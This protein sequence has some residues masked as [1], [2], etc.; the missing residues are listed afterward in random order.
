MTGL[1]VSFRW[2][3]SELHVA[4]WSAFGTRLPRCNNRSKPLHLDAVMGKA[5]LLNGI[6]GKLLREVAKLTERAVR[7]R[8]IPCSTSDER[9]KNTTTWHSCSELPPSLWAAKTSAPTLVRH[10]RHG[11]VPFCALSGALGQRPG[12]LDKL[13]NIPGVVFRRIPIPLLE[14]SPDTLKQTSGTRLST[15]VD[16]HGG[17][18]RSPAE[19]QQRGWPPPEGSDWTP[20][21]GLTSPSRRMFFAAPAGLPQVPTRDTRSPLQFTACRPRDLLRALGGCYPVPREKN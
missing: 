9:S 7:Q 8:A 6:A 17:S 5:A 12:R 19:G 10:W 15:C 14:G 2:A 20:S 13:T 18:P 11:G 16:T 4:D 3:A 1:I 21:W